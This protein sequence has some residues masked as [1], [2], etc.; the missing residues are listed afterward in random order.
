MTTESNWYKQSRVLVGKYADIFLELSEVERA[1]GDLRRAA[2]LHE[3]LSE[4][5]SEMEKPLDEAK[6]ELDWYGNSYAETDIIDGHFFYDNHFVDC[7]IKDCER[8]LKKLESFTNLTQK[9][10]QLFRKW[11]LINEQ[12]LT[13]AA[14]ELTRRGITVKPREPVEEPDVVTET[15]KRVR[16]TVQT[17]AA[18]ERDCEEDVRNNPEQ[19]TLIRR[20]YRKAI[21]RLREG[22]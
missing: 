20:T 16:E 17:I 2:R 19:E 10:E 12:H 21:D 22:S 7:V 13:F 8:E 3:Q 9:E 18:L 15:R 5:V 6:R 4:I 14:E 11:R 1:N